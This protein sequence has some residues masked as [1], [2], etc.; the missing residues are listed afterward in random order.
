M[1]QRYT[2]LLWPLAAIPCLVAQPYTLTHNEQLPAGSEYQL[3]EV[4]N[5]TAIDTTLGQ[6]VTW[7]HNDLVA[8]GP[9]LDVSI[10]APA[11]S[12]YGGSFPTANYCVYESVIPRYSYFTNTPEGYS[13]I[14][15]W[16]NVLG[17]YS[18][19]QTELV[20]PV[21]YGATNSDTWAN[22]TVS[23]PGTYEYTVIG[24]GTLV[25][26]SGTWNDVLL[27]R[28][29]SENL[30][31]FYQYAWISATNGA[32]L[33]LYNQASL[34][35]PAS[36]Q[37]ITSLDVGIED[38]SDDLDLRLHAPGNG[39]L[40]LTYSAAAPMTYRI[41]DSA[42]RMLTTGRTQAS[43]QARTEI[44]DIS[45]LGTGIHLIELTSDD[46]RHTLRFF[47]DQ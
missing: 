25:L 16:R 44:L 8:T 6:N 40:P 35:G 45:M 3:R 1:F 29:R 14:G 4:Q 15:F 46:Q 19:P 41:M 26:P 13:R 32:Y 20:Y 28:V 9:Q 7:Q 47:V 22:N 36:A 24:T 37:M 21:T 39:L 12:P 5:L 34:F 10:L 2:A 43:A 18:D 17:T 27:L 33:L 42:G 31:A 11:S 30:I 23:F 38:I